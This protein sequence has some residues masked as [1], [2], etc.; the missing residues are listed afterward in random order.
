MAEPWWASGP[1]AGCP[2]RLGAAAAYDA[3]LAAGAAE[4]D[5][6]AA[7]LATRDRAQ[8]ERGRM[9]TIREVAVAQATLSARGAALAEREAALA[10]REAAL[11]EREAALAEREAAAQAER[12]R[13]ESDLALRYQVLFGLQQDQYDRE[14]TLALYDRTLSR[15]YMAMITVAER[16][17]NATIRSALP[18]CNGEVKAAYDT[19]LAA[20]QWLVAS[21]D[22]KD[23]DP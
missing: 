9:L 20:L 3:A 2:A 17:A 5:H 18:N 21:P 15:R 13:Q 11:A 1:G 12:E 10:E 7:A 19:V 8:A 4:L 23:L 6:W 22:V 14:E 16:A